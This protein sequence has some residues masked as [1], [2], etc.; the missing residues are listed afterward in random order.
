MDTSTREEDSSSP[1]H[2][3]PR[4]RPPTQ[5]NSNSNFRRTTSRPHSIGA[6]II[7][8]P[9]LVKGW[10]YYD[11]SADQRDIQKYF[12]TINVGASTEESFLEQQYQPTDTSSNGGDSKRSSRRERRSYIRSSSAHEPIPDDD[13]EEA[14]N[15]LVT[16][17]E[18][19]AVVSPEEKKDCC[20][21]LVRLFSPIIGIFLAVVASS[22]LALVSIL[23]ENLTD[24]HPYSV[25]VW[26]SQ[27]LL[28]P[29]FILLL[30]PCQMKSV[31]LT[32]V[33]IPRSPTN[34]PIFTLFLLLLRALF[35]YSAAL[36]TIWSLY[37]TSSENTT[38]IFWLNPLFV[39]LTAWL[40]LK[41]K[42][43]LVPVLTA[44]LVIFGVGAII[45]PSIF[46]ERLPLQNSL[47]I[48]CS[49]AVAAMLLEGVLSTI[50][51]RHL[52]HVHF[53]LVTFI[54]GLVGTAGALFLYYIQH[55]KF[56]LPVDGTDQVVSVVLCVLVFFG[57]TGLF[58]ALKH[59]QAGIFA[60]SNCW[61]VPMLLVWRHRYFHSET[62]NVSNS[63]RYTKLTFFSDAY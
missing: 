39:I 10:Q 18:I 1:T 57:Q 54:Y 56:Q 37:H 45:Q 55:N 7:S 59:E 53:A 11:N 34:S 8:N 58:G 13:D 5:S 22:N 25:L 48:G 23:S 42:S 20:A 43:G 28:W 51:L 24:Y 21:T 49:L 61:H 47:T 63:L 38:M 12:S 6:M 31:S 52:R 44:I 46:N 9:K 60:V 40:V 15:D 26:T 3:V 33:H 62:L 2:F 36:L 32:Q 4:R 41:E 29:S 27:G 14:K 19:K 50:I 17:I 35:G 16:G 30:C